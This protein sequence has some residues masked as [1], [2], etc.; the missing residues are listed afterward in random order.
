MHSVNIFIKSYS[1]K[2]NWQFYLNFRKCT[3]FEQWCLLSSNVI[4]KFSEI[5]KIENFTIIT[6]LNS[7]CS[8]GVC[9]AKPAEMFKPSRLKDLQFWK[10]LRITFGVRLNRFSKIY[11]KDYMHW[12][13]N[14]SCFI[15]S[16]FICMLSFKNVY[17]IIN[18]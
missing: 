4:S 2:A 12:V 13:R 16:L 10:V 7:K 8:F 5:R 17:A 9:R 3:S 6:N 14:L 18:N 15:I 11:E 1:N